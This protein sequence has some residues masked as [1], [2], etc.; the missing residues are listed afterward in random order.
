MGGFIHWAY[1]GTNHKPISF[2]NPPL[3]PVFG[4]S[5]SLQLAKDLIKVAG[6][7]NSAGDGNLFNGGIAIAKLLF[8]VCDALDQNVGDDCGSVFFFEFPA[9]VEFADEKVFCEKV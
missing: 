4:S 7:C 6:I 2:L 5:A 9:E 1:T 3:L 8:C